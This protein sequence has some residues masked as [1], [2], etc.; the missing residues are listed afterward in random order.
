MDYQ[1]MFNLAITAA[2]F[3]GGW[4]LNRIYSAIDRLDTDVRNLPHVYVGKDDYKNDLKEVKH[5][6]SKIFD[7]LDEKA[8]K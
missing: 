1:E 3:F 6:L 4:T 7:K 2:A 8:D 5:L